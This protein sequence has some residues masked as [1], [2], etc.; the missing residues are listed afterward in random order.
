MRSG[1]TG[2]GLMDA[3]LVYGDADGSGHEVS[4][5][6]GLAV[7][8]R[9]RRGSGATGGTGPMGGAE[10]GPVVPMGGTEPPL[11]GGKKE[12]EKDRASGNETAL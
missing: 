7:G 8:L 6:V 9:A 3:V 1:S 10:G 5:W 2:V 12:E 11:Q 4:L